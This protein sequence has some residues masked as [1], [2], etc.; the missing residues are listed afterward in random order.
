MKRRVQLARDA[1]ALGHESIARGYDSHC[2]DEIHDHAMAFGIFASTYALL[3]DRVRSQYMCQWLQNDAVKPN[4]ATGWGLPFKWGAFS[5]DDK[6]SVTVVYGVTSALAIRG[7]IDYSSTFGADIPNCVVKFLD[8]YLQFFVE[9]PEGGYFGYSD[10]P[11]DLKSVFNVS[12]LLA[13]QYARAGKLLNRADYK[14]V[15]RLVADDIMANAQSSPVGDFWS[16]GANIDRPNDAV[17]A[18]YAVQGLID[19]NRWLDTGYKLDLATRYLRKFVRNGRAFEYVRHGNLEP[20]L[21]QRPARAW[22]VGMLLYTACE[23]SDKYLQGLVEAALPAYRHENGQYGI[24]PASKVSYPRHQA[25]IALG[26]AR[27]AKAEYSGAKMTKTHQPHIVSI[28]LNGVA[29][30]SRVIKTAKSAEEAGFKATI[31]GMSKVEKVTK[32]TIEGVNVVLVPSPLT[33]LQSRKMWPS[34]KDQRQLWMLV[35]GALKEILPVVKN[36]NPSLIHSHDMSG[37][38]VGA[39]VTKF[40]AAGGKSVPWVHDLHEFVVGLTTVPENYRKSSVEYERRYLRQ[41]DHLLTVSDRLAQEVQGIYHLRQAPTVIYNAPVARDVDPSEPDVRSVLGLPNSVPLAVYIGVAKKE[42]GCET[43][44]DAIAQNSNLHICFVSDSGY[45]DQLQERALAH[46]M[47]DRFHRVPYVPT[48]QVSS[49]I[50]TADF[51]T[52]GLIHYPNGEVA[53]PNKLFEYLQAGLPLVVSDVA[54]MKRFVEAYNVGAVFEAENAESCGAAMQ[55]VIRDTELF[56]AN[57]TKD[58]TNKFSWQEQSRKIGDIYSDLLQKFR[59]NLRSKIV[60]G[61]GSANLDLLAQKM[62]ISDTKTGVISVDQPEFACDFYANPTVL[63]DRAGML[64]GL[65]SRYHTFLESF[66]F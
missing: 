11:A 36:L 23:A 52:H 42:R 25:H 43:I 54:E 33:D 62:D 57:I 64:S 21:Q 59:T 49:F 66:T 53:L 45:V 2:Q 14:R 8:Y 17:H 18:S 19:V 61:D 56:R 16:Y 6:N 30:D 63:S 55:S 39:A 26:L 34:D 65:V 4:G 5:S 27:S 10:Q 60:I 58:L 48:D 46:G 22:G 29:G 3:G 12:S 7:L 20:K 38:R 24:L 13:G 1:V 40:L 15:A 32:A 35:E 50:R 44:L 47:G 31:V 41:P 9:T 37:L 51:G 28:V